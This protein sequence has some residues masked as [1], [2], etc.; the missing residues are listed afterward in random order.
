MLDSVSVSGFRK[1]YLLRVVVGL[2]LSCFIR[3]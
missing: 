3:E 2:A 1:S